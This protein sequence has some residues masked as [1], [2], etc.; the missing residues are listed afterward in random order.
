MM[1]GLQT[2][3]KMSKDTFQD[4]SRKFAEKLDLRSQAAARLNT[5]KQPNTTQF[6]L[7]PNWTP[8]PTHFLVPNVQQPGTHLLHQYQGT[9]FPYAGRGH[10]TVQTPQPR[11]TVMYNPKQRKF[12]RTATVLVQPL[13][14]PN[15]QKFCTHC[16]LQYHTVEEC[17]SLHPKLEAYKSCQKTEMP[18]L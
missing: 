10:F 3:V 17:F 15:D 6:L 4:L 7:P 5:F 13:K 14:P 11:Q 16:Q 8:D 18:N 9:P 2:A 1:D 12:G